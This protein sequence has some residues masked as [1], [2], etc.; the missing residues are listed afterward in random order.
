MTYEEAQELKTSKDVLDVFEIDTY[1]TI[2]CK[3][4]RPKEC[5]GR[6]VTLMMIVSQCKFFEPKDVG[7]KLVSESK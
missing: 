7:L 2:C 5:I 6:F 1:E 4:K 3:C